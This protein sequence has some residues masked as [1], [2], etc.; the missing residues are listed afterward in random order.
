MTSITIHSQLV[1]ISV[2]DFTMELKIEIPVKYIVN[3]M[4]RIMGVLQRVQL[5]EF[6]PSL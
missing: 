4:H 1:H 3:D 6:D 5:V 2:R